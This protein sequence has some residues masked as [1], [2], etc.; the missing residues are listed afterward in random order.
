MPFTELL[1]LIRPWYLLFQSSFLQT[2][3]SSCLSF[4]TTSAP[5]PLQQQIKPLFLLVTHSSFWLPTPPC[6]PYFPSAKA[7]CQSFG[8]ENSLWPPCN[9]LCRM[10]CSVQECSCG[11][12]RNNPHINS[13]EHWKKKKITVWIQ[14]YSKLWFIFGEVSAWRDILFIYLFWGSHQTKNGHNFSFL[15]KNS[16]DFNSSRC[17]IICHNYLL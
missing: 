13:Q 12:W 2:S 4:P 1:V 10:N 7:G 11:L 6:I 17:C 9:G 5:L 15:L 16:Q 3:S 14:S 8:E